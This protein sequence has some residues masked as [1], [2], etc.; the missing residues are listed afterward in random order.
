MTDLSLVGR[1]GL[2]CGA[3]GIYRAYR[4]GGE[5]LK[6][7][8][9]SFDCSPQLVRCEGCQELTSECWGNNCKIVNC[10][11]GKGLSFCYECKDLDR[12][13]EYSSL[14][15]GYRELGVDLKG[16]L[17]R[18]ESVIQRAGSKKRTRSGDAGRAESLCH[19]IWKNVINVERR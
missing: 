11:R 15:E 18:I 17:K 14:Y 1:C 8:T 7:V 5:Y 19:T 4:D 16:N 12:C 9:E 2:Y 6:K 13:E 3:C 10:L